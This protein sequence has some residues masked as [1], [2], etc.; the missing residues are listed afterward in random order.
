MDTSSQSQN[1]HSITTWLYYLP[2]PMILLAGIGLLVAYFKVTNTTVECIDNTA[3]IDKCH[4]EYC[5]SLKSDVE[6]GIHDMITKD[7]TKDFL[8][9]S[10]SSSYVA[11]DWSPN[12]IILGYGI[13][14]YYQGSE[15]NAN[16]CYKKINVALTGDSTT[17]NIS[18]TITSCFKLTK[19]KQEL[20]II[21][22]ALIGFAV[23]V[24]IVQ[25]IYSVKYSQKVIQ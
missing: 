2:A 1:E 18:G 15:K 20:A 8:K 4:N 22:S 10:D 9:N 16:G 25:V 14:T 11:S 6:Y 12:P 19:K 13:S 3:G 23:L 21:G 7:E 17:D 5:D 24:I